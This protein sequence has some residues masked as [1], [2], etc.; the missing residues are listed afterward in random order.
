M[1]GRNGGVAR[2][3]G[4]AVMDV[5]VG[6]IL[7]ACGGFCA[8]LGVALLRARRGRSRLDGTLEGVSV[9]FG[10]LFRTAQHLKKAAADQKERG[11]VF[12]SASEDLSAAAAASGEALSR[13]VAKTAE[14]GA[15]SGKFTQENEEYVRLVQQVYSG[16]ETISRQSERI[17]AAMEELS[18]AEESL[19]T[20]DEIT[21][22]A[23]L[24][25]FN[26]AIEAE[27]ASAA[28]GHLTGFHAVAHEMKQLADRTRVSAQDIRTRFVHAFRHVEESA[29]ELNRMQGALL[30]HTKEMKDRSERAQGTIQTM[31]DAVRS[32]VE[33][34]SAIQDRFK[35]LVEAV[36]QIAEA[37]RGSVS[38]SG[39]LGQR[40]E[41]LQ[42]DV[43][44]LN[45][46]LALVSGALHGTQI[47][48]LSPDVA[49]QKMGDFAVIVDVREPQEFNDELGHVSGARLLTIGD[50][51]PEAL[52][53]AGFDKRQPVL[54]ICR[55]G[56]RSTRAAQIAQS[57]GFRRVFNLQGGMLA[58]NQ[59]KKAVARESSRTFAA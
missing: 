57:A 41:S 22:S 15:L 37:A 55:S 39:A 46:N 35:D 7:S 38:A 26:A 30:G 2:A 13:S 44:H 4:G 54:F 48:D 49:E 14:L 34:Q 1:T 21:F 9:V 59:A 28:G 25:A 50:S 36:G 58:W 47:V 5:V 53:S 24:L 17:R 29:E 12:T 8:G 20:I 10:G 18:T 19:Q 42:Q 6:L 43:E 56:G 23:R 16:V 52:A 40:S 51:F 32:A 11:D 31:E 33:N 45:K 27:H 3:R